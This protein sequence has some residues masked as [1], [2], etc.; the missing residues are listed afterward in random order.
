MTQPHIVPRTSEDQGE[1][2]RLSRLATDLLRQLIDSGTPSIE[3]IAWY[4]GG[5][6]DDVL[7]MAEG[8]QRMTPTARRNLARVALAFAPGMGKHTARRLLQR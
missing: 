3:V 1:E 4:L 8:V 2:Q 6:T 5:S 7:C